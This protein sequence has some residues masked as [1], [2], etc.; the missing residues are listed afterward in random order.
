MPSVNTIIPLIGGKYYHIYNR[1][2]NKS[3]IFFKQENYSYF[4]LLW[5]KYL[6]DNVNVL[7]YCLIP[8]HFHFLIKLNEKI[9]IQDGENRIEITDEIMIGK[10]VSE[11]F[12]RLFIAYSQAVNIQENRTGS[13]FQRNFKRIE[14]ED[15]NHL[16]YLF[17]YIHYNPEHHRLI[18]DFKDYRFSSFKAYITNQSTRIAKHFGLEIFDGKN[19]FLDYHK[20]QHEEKEFLTLE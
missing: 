3:Q 14:I 2:I 9:S 16:K 6:S 5:K 1:G 15:D 11:A 20:Y 18:S 4:L 7:A 8:N 19:N 12:R 10:N 13:L 17:F